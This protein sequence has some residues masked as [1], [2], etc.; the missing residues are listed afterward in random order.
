MP[1][2]GRVDGGLLGLDVR[3][4]L[5]VLEVEQNISLLHMVA[6]FDN[7]IGNLTDAFAQ[8]VGIGLGADLA[9]GG[10]QGDQVL[11]ASTRP[12][13]TTTTFWLAL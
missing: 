11:R 8:D 4:R 10:D 7:D 3:S 2:I 13:C 9:R 5:N 12:V 1:A 6:L